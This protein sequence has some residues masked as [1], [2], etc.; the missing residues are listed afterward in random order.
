MQPYRS[1]APPTEMSAK[2]RRGRGRRLPCDA[3]TWLMISGS[4]QSIVCHQLLRRDRPLTFSIRLMIAG[5]AMVLALVALAVAGGQ[6]RLILAGAAIS[7]SMLIADS[8]SFVAGQS[9]HGLRWCVARVQHPRA[10]ADDTAWA[11]QVLALVPRFERWLAGGRLPSEVLQEAFYEPGRIDLYDYGW[12]IVYLSFFVVPHLVALLLLWRSRKLFWHYAFAT[13]MLFSL[14]M[15]GFFIIPT[16]PPWLVTEVA[17]SGNFADMRRITEAVLVR[18]DLPVRLFNHPELGTLRERVSPGAQ[19][20]R[21]DALDPLRGE[22]SCRAFGAES[23]RSPLRGGGRL[24]RPH[25]HRARL[26]GRALCNR[27][28][29]GWRPRMGRLGRGRLVH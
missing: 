4:A 14:A 11:N 20:D 27:P 18:M 17:P 15:V 21:R 3:G 13:A 7:I 23:W 6:W 10:S 24:P 25:E 16:S 12:T 26:S 19:S 5:G 9:G 1:P 29:G 22:R 2:S 28:G 8:L